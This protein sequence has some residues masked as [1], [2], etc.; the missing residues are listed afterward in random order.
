MTNENASLAQRIAMS[1]GRDALSQR[2]AVVSRLAMRDFSEDQR[3]NLAKSGAA[4]P[5]GS[6]PI[7]TVTDLRNAIQAYGRSNPD[8][9][10]KVKAHIIKRARAIG[11]ADLLPDAWD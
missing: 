9:R 11:A 2:S 6:Y 1:I 10:A 4:L 5:D 8:D 7:V 3:K